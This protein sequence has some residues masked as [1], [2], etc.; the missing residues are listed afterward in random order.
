MED[1]YGTPGRS[2]TWVTR[3]VAALV[4]V[5]GLALIGWIVVVNT[6][7]D[8]KI[9]VL[10]FAVSDEH[11]VTTDVDVFIKDGV[12]DVTCVVRAGATDGALVG[13][14]RFP[15]VPGRQTVEIRTD[16]MATTVME[17]E[18]TVGESAD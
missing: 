7:P 2:T 15:A 9:V 13:E 5:A 6:G 14:V 17:G 1:R 16:R 8:T 18:C 4:A 11:H 12:R 3:T 10:T